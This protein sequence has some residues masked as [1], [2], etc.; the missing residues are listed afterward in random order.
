MATTILL[1][2]RPGVGKTTVIRQIAEELGDA[3]GGFYTS[4][5]REH[6]QRKGFKLVTLDGQKATLAHTDIEAGPRVSKYRV[7]LP[8]LDEIG[9]VAIRGALERAQ[10]VII[11]EIGKMELF[12]EQFREAVKEA[13]YSD[14]PAI[15]TA[16]SGRNPWV[17]ELKNL[18]QVTVLEVTP[19]NRD[20]M[21][22]RVLGLLRS[23]SGQQR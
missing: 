7:N 19:A 9:V 2:G 1:T 21:A 20:G 14:K 18:P 16:M 15:G 10:Y 5:I 12:S 3:A 13:V 6:G 11:D 17:D 22:K 4:E 23:P 8:A